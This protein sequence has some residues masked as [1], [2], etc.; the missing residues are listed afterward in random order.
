MLIAS[1]NLRDGGIDEGNAGRLGRQLRLLA[2]IGADVVLIQEAKHW[3]ECGGRGVHMAEWMLGA[4]VYLVTA[5]RHGCHLS[6]LVRNGSNIEVL[7]SRHERHAPFWH[8]QAR[9]CCKVA[10]MKMIF[11]STHFSPFSPDLRVL[12][13]QANSDLAVAVTVLG[14][15]FND[16]GL[17]ETTNWGSLPGAS[18]AYPPNGCDS[19]LPRSYKPLATLPSGNQALGS[20]KPVFSSFRTISACRRTPTLSM[21]ADELGQIPDHSTLG[22]VKWPRTR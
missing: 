8:A 19:A 18:C 16:P 2:G 10:G 20:R 21:S 13:A 4:R 15:D 11:A 3:L 9:I 22:I 12:E 14:G 5:P 6:V 1:W 17:E 7:R